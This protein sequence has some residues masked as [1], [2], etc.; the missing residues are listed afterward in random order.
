MLDIN[1]EE[2]ENKLEMRLSENSTHPL[3]STSGT[4]LPVGS[5][6]SSPPTL[7]VVPSGVLES[8]VC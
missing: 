2:I 6:G 5:G 4:S 7:P 1:N 3:R 8:L